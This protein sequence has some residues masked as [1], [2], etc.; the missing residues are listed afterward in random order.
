VAEPEDAG[1]V[2]EIRDPALNREGIVQEVHRRIARRQA[3]GSYDIDPETLGPETLRPDRYHFPADGM[4]PGFPGLHPALA[5]LLAEGRLREP[6]FTST[7]PLIGPLIVAVRRFW[8]W[9]ST[10]WYVRPI[11][12]QQSEVNMRTAGVVSDLAQWHE[13]G[14]N[15]LHLLEARMAELEARLARVEA[16]EGP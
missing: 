3:E 9:M 14:T 11:L 5:E 10:K 2:I 1:T 12:A 4:D 8:N 7:A 13:L 6:H 15:R 16:E